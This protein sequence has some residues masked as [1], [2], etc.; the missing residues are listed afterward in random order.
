MSK[1]VYIVFPAGAYVFLDEEI[2]AVPTETNRL[3]VTKA[4][5]QDVAHLSLC[6]PHIEEISSIIHS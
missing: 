3:L 1:P 6:S 5:P 2:E 4:L